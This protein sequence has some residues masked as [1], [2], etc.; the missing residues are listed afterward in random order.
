[1]SIMLE[2]EAFGGRHNCYLFI[3]IHVTRKCYFVY[4]NLF[5]GILLDTLIIDNSL[6]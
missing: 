3:I 5:T 1:M 4:L 2:H 6:Y